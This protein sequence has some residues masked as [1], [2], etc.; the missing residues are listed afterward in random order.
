MATGCLILNSSKG[1]VDVF[2]LRLDP[3]EAGYFDNDPSRSHETVWGLYS[4][5]PLTTKSTAAA[6]NNISGRYPGAL[7]PGDP[8]DPG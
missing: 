7:R 3:D 1:R 8:Q 2:G 5:F 4:T 6:L